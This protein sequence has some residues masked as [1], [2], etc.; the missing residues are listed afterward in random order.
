MSDSRVA[1]ITGGGTG[2]GAATAEELA[3]IGLKIVV[4]GR[5]PRPLERVVALIEGRGGQAMGLPA[6]VANYEAIEEVVNRTVECYGRIDL[7]VANAGVHEV[8]SIDTGDPA[9]W[10]QLIQINVMGVLNAVR[11][12]LPLMYR[13]GAGHVVV[14]SSV[15]GRVTYV[16]E[17]AYVS[18]KHAITAFADCLRQEASPKGVRVTVLEPGL[19]DT[20]LADN[21]YAAEMKK[22]VRPLLPSDCARAIRF[23]FEQPPNVG[24]NEI[25]M[26]P[27]KQVL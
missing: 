16:G 24:I 12:V 21:P 2:I 17:T 1:L 5:R 11:A 27:V 20:P 9:R 6:D 23:A 7:L 4:V 14:V 19:V 26:R 22:T 10:S 3:G 25:V 15:S 8:S 13:Q 18:S